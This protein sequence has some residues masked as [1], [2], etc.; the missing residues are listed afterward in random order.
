[1]TNDEIIYR[2][3]KTQ[4]NYT[5]G[6]H[7]IVTQEFQTFDGEGQSYTT[8]RNRDYCVTFTDKNCP[9]AQYLTTT[10]SDDSI[11]SITFKKDADLFAVPTIQLSN[12]S[13]LFVFT[14][15]DGSIVQHYPHRADTTLI[16]TGSK[17]SILAETRRCILVDVRS[18]PLCRKSPR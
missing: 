16:D 6:L 11:F 2:V 7:K 8:I 17:K 1:M 10:F 12:R 5:P 3:D 15:A 4:T 14:Q 9:S 18:P 13:G